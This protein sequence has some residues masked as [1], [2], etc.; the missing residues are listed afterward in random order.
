MLI[1]E[2]INPQIIS[3][4]SYCGHGSKVLIADGN[5]P[6]DEKTG[7]AKKVYLSL[8][9]GNPTVT[10]VLSALKT[11]V[12]IEKYTVMDPETGD[13]PEVY[14]LFEEELSGI[15][16][17][18]VSRSKFY[19]LCNS[20]NDVKLA[21]LTGDIRTFSNILLTIGVRNA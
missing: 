15:P 1:N 11:S 9:A 7:N 17:E 4:L 18:K 5:Y 2:L 3:A 10:E 13:I 12:N 6:L 8:T 16:Y 19:E 14:P 20:S 21:I